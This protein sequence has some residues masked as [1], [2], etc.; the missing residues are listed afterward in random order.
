[1][2][3][4]SSTA[5]RIDH[6]ATSYP[7]LQSRVHSTPVL[8]KVPGRI[9]PAGGSAEALPV[10]V[11]RFMGVLVHPIPKCEME[12]RFGCFREGGKVYLDWS[13]ALPSWFGVEPGDRLEVAGRSF[14]ILGRDEMPIVYSALY[15]CEI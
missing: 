12:A 4:Q 13:R 15:V 10:N 9:I 6:T 7:P 8:E 11:Q 2:T 3:K 1:M 14:N 5:E